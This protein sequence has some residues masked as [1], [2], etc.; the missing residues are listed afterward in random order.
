MVY[1]LQ[2]LYI[3]ESFAKNLKENILNQTKLITF[4]FSRYKSGNGVNN[5][6]SSRMKVLPLEVCT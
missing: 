4:I 5:A 3:F 6:L 1:F 2:I